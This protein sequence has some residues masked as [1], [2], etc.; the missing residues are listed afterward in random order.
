MT[1]FVLSLWENTDGANFF[2]PVYNNFVVYLHHDCIFLPL[3][4]RIHNNI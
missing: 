2:W 1:A 4:M 3:Q